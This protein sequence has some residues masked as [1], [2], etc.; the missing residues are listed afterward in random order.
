MTKRKLTCESCGTLGC[1]LDTKYPDFCVTQNMDGDNIDKALDTYKDNE[2]LLKMMQ[3]S[4]EIE[5]EGYLKWTRIEETIKFIKRMDFK[6]VGIATCVSFMNEV[7][8]LTKI[9]KHH[10]IEFRTA[11]C[12][13][14]AIDK[15]EVGI[16]DE[17][18]IRKGGHESMCNPILQAKFL[19][20]EGT[21]FNIVF[22]LCVGHDTLFNMHSKAPF[23]TLVVKDRVTCHNPVAPLHYTDGIYKR[24]L[25]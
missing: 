11:C 21:D 7:R 15:N 1:R 9:L 6:L 12:K 24:L 8:T 2:F 25:D 16:E 3:V 19:E 18:K 17:K 4:S 5:S 23:T 10:G 14:G 13:V 22:G 20:E